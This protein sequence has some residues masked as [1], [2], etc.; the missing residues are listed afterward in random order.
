MANA[1]K[2]T[3]KLAK[4]TVKRFL[5]AGVLMQKVDRQVEQGKLFAGKTGASIRI[6]R[7]VMFPS[8]DNAVIGAGEITD[9]EEGVV[10]VTLDNY[11]KVVY[12]LTNEDLTLRAEDLA[13]RYG[14]PAAQRISQDVESSIADAAYKGFTNF[15]GTPG[16]TPSTFLE[17]A[18]QGA[19]L[20]E[21]GVEEMDRV[22]FYD[23][24]ATVALSNGLTGVNPTEIATTAIER[25]KIGRYGNFDL[26]QSASLKKHTVGAYG[27][28]PLVNGASQNVTY[29][30]SK[31]TNTQTLLTDGWTN[32][33]TGILKAGDKI[34]LAGVN[35]VN[36]MTGEDTGRLM[37]FTVTADADSGAATGPATLTISPPIITSGAYKTCT[38]APANN[39]AITVKTGTASTAYRQNLAFHPNAVTLAFAR[40]DVPTE[41]VDA[42]RITH[43]GVSM[44]VF[45]QFSITLKKTILSFDALWAVKVQNP[46]WGVVTTG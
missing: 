27:G 6:R 7:P 20:S 17:V 44:S 11:K 13:E 31:D 15:L 18:N 26:F 16:T 46:Q 5:N 8:S 42:T 41:G 45:K 30:A 19:V 4:I 43:D 25:A 12:A 22:A 9:I 14:K 10:T 32:S 40:L 34:T 33:I 21:L 36:I 35:S 29:A 39:A 3:D 37:T 1:L 24:A 2:V 38:A 28:T 23:P